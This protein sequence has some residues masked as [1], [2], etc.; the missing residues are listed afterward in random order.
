M[1]RSRVMLDIPHEVWNKVIADGNAA[2]LDE[3]PSVVESLAQE[4]SLTIGATLRGGHAAFVVE[5]TLADGTAAVLKVGV[6]GTRRELGY[7]ATVLRLADGDGCARL[8]RDDLD[9][10][11]LLLERLG[12]PLYDVVAD[13]AA[14]HDMLCDVAARLW[15]P[16][17]PEVDLPTGAD[18]AIEYANLLPRLWEQTGRACSRA[19]VED[20]LACADRRR[21]A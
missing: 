21:R 1:T 9:R 3:L 13:P 14:R 4:W 18:K 17:A 6:P 12:A 5:A 16:V 20:A 11:A 7:E 19:A 8:L 15:R 2:W 10:D